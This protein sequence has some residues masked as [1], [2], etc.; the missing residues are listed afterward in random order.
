MLLQ[1]ILVVF[2]APHREEALEDVNQD[3][4]VDDRDQV[5]ERSGHGGANQ[6]RHVVQRRSLVDEVAADRLDSDSNE[7]REH[8]HDR[9]VAQREKKPTPS[10]RLPSAI[11]LRVVLSM[12]AMWSASTA[13]RNPSV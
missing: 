5:E 8:E 7:E 3:H 9:G 6:T 11:S 2:A 1:L 12:A 4:H 13:W 10:G